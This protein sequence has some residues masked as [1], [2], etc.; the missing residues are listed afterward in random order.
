VNLGVG[1]NAASRKKLLALAQKRARWSCTAAVTST[2]RPRRTCRFVEALR[3]WVHWA[4]AEQLRA[5]LGA[6]ASE[7]AKFAPEIESKL[8]AL[9]P[10]RRSRP[11]EE[12]LRLFDHVARLLQTLAAAARAAV[13]Y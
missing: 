4:S 1:K 7:I 9:P 8:G 13:L 12:R 6:S 2:K 5:Q 11:N 3:E 10:T